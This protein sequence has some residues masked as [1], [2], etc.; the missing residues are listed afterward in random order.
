MRVTAEFL[1]D[2]G[3]ILLRLLGTI[4]PPSNVQTGIYTVS[5]FATRNP[6]QFDIEADQIVDNEVNIYLSNTNPFPEEITVVLPDLTQQI[7]SVA[8]VKKPPPED[9]LHEQP[10]E[11]IIPREPPPHNPSEMLPAPDEM[12]PPDYPP[13]WVELSFANANPLKVGAGLDLD[14]ATI[15]Y[16]GGGPGRILSP[17]IVQEFVNQPPYKIYAPTFLEGTFSNTLQY[18]DFTTSYIPSGFLDPVPDG[19]SIIQSDPDSLIRVAIDTLSTIHSFQVTWFLRPNFQDYTLAP[20]ITIITP[21]VSNILQVMLEPAS[22]NSLGTAQLVSANALFSSTP[23]VLSGPTI[24]TLDVQTDPGPVKIVWQ[25]T[26][27]N[28]NAQYL[29]VG[30]AIASSYPTV[31]SWINYPDTSVADNI[32]VTNL[33]FT[34]RW[35][36]NAGYIRVDS[37][38]LDL[39]EPFSWSIYFTSTSQILLQVVGGILSS[40]FSASTVDLRPLLTTEGYKLTWVN[41]Q[42]NLISGATTTVLSFILGALPNPLLTDTLNINLS[43][44]TPTGG[45]SRIK[46]FVFKPA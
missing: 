3:R 2:Q 38:Q 14:L 28:N 9:I 18:A 17:S 11:T 29:S 24:L 6:L 27:G 22:T 31:H 15:S 20:P 46:Y 25:Q 7:V 12:S 42:F 4:T 21:F 40:D 35:N 1:F 16:T 30:A 8:L 44:Y 39:G 41:G 5:Y 37:L 33:D 10:F 26:E 43:S 34:G 23:V 36:F 19:W 32:A 13:Y 45:S